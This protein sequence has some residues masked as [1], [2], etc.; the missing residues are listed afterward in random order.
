[1]AD[2]LPFGP[3]VVTYPTGATTLGGNVSTTVATTTFSTLFA[4][5]N[6]RRGAMI[7]NKGT[8][9]MYISEGTSLASCS[10]STSFALTTTAGA[11]V[12]VANY[13]PAVLTGQIN[14]AGSTTTSNAFYAVEW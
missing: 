14:I 9:V 8:V 10:T 11:N 13:G 12:W 4:A 1:M 5:S 6:A 3:N 2:N 7:Q